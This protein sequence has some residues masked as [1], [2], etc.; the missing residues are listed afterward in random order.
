MRTIRAYT[1]FEEKEVQ[2]DGKPVK[3]LA[4]LFTRDLEGTTP[5]SLFATK[6]FDDVLLVGIQAEDGKA[7]W[8]KSESRLNILHVVLCFPNENRS[9]PIC[10]FLYAQVKSNGG[11]SRAEACVHDRG[12]WEHEFSIS[13]RTSCANKKKPA[14]FHEV[15]VGGSSG[16]SG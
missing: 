8:K 1:V 12:I 7:Q 16:T 11:F 15:V 6:L 2:Q 5:T 10:T 9:C 3:S 13:V 4:C 14:F